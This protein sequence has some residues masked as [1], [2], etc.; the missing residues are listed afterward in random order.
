MFMLDMLDSLPRL[1]LSDDHLRTIIWVMREC[2]T[3]DVPAFSQLRKVQNDMKAELKLDP[4]HHTSSSGRHFYMNH[5]V[6]LFALVS[7][8]YSGPGLARQA[9]FTGTNVFQGLV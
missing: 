9:E 6:K 3:P 8:I 1:R 5:A 4:E 7:A 2:G